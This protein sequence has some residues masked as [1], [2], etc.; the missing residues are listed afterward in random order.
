MLKILPHSRPTLTV[1]I[2]SELLVI[3]VLAAGCGMRTVVGDHTTTRTAKSS[4]ARMT[5]TIAF[6]KKRDTFGPPQPGARPALTAQ[7]AW[8]RFAHPGSRSSPIPSGTTVHLGSLT[9]VMGPVGLHGKV[10][11]RVRGELAYGYSYH[12]CPTSQAPGGTV[13]ANPCIAWAFLNANN[14]NFIV[15]DYETN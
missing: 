13:P 15:L 5:T 2:I 6:G 7:Q 12:Q 8:A 4:S 11:Y 3:G 10:A 14:G 9:V 1:V